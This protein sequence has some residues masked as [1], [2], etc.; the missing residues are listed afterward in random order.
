MLFPPEM[1]SGAF[2]SGFV[3]YYCGVHADIIHAL[4]YKQLYHSFFIFYFT[5][6]LYD[7]FAHRVL[8]EK[9]Q[10]LVWPDIR[11]P[12]FPT[13]SAVDPNLVR[14]ELF[15]FSL[16]VC[17]HGSPQNLKFVTVEV[18]GEFTLCCSGFLPGLCL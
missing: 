11:G 6:W 9:L 8:I 2:C 4:G 17:Y 1:Q 7:C 3:L 15:L 18:P 13:I 10:C 14:S 5:P 12:G 16:S